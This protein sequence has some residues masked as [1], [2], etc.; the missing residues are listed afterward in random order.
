MTLNSASR[1][2]PPSAATNP[3]VDRDR[4]GPIR[5]LSESFLS[6]FIAVL[7]F[8]TFAAE[9]YMISTGSMAP[10]L[11]GFHKR[12]ECPKCGF[13]FPFGVAYDSDNPDDAEEL[14]RLRSR[15]VCP[16]CGQTRIDVSDVPRNHGDQLLVN[17]QAYLY[18]SPQRW[19]VIVFR[20]PAKP[21]E[22]YVKR[23]AGLPGDQI[24]LNDGDVIING[25]I[26]RKSYEQLRAMRIIVNDHN[27][28]PSDDPGYRP[29][30]QVA[31]NEAAN[32][33]DS[34]K[35]GGWKVSDHGFILRDGHA[36]RPDREPYHWVEYRHWIRSG[37]LHETSVHL[38]E[39]PGEVHSSSV[40]R[41]GLRY[42]PQ[43]QT[44]SCTGALP[45]GALKQILTLTDDKP[46][47]DAFVELYDASHV[48]PLTDDYGYNP[49]ESGAVPN[50]VRDVMVSARVRLEGGSGEFAIQM[51]DDG[52][53]NFSCVFDASQ[54]E[55]RLLVGDSEEP[56]A[57]GSWPQALDH[58]PVTI[59]MS[60]IDRQLIVAVDGRVTM[61]P[62]PFETPSGTPVPR[63]AARFGARGL[64]VQVDE[65]K[66]YRDV[67]YTSSRCRNAVN[68]PLALRDDEYF[69]LG[70][71]S[72]VSHDSRR[73]DEAPVHRSLLLGKPFLV[74]LPSKPGRL[75]IGNYVMHLRMPDT[76]R[77]R[78]LK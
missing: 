37:G 11:S 70:D 74:H 61:T 50:F 22:A 35:S 43:A 44:L 4:R 8:R 55:I 18:R 41:A 33:N 1:S 51:T 6:L 40:P 45:D 14:T 72:P 29:H 23:V 54:R 66:L 7:L 46:F 65:L 25:Q 26:S 20:N 24:Q 56:V 15:A 48:T 60:T 32:P 71:N 67:Y 9:G 78:F 64:D 2:A 73:W 19:E 16:N 42:D 28:Q 34:A 36:R 27:H 58:G 57:T 5:S 31:S 21:T 12:V 39:W 63:K 53:R 62:W 69:V 13:L 47:G 10:F 59:E 76:E 17:K 30:W 52:V 3:P 75:R 49:V 38:A 77:I 68:R